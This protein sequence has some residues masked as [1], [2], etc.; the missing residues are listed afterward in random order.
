MAAT[1]AARGV[2]SCSLLF[3]FIL[4]ESITGALRKHALEM[5]E[6]L[7]PICPAFSPLADL[8]DCKRICNV[9]L[10]VAELKFPVNK[11]GKTVQASSQLIE[12]I[13]ELLDNIAA[14]LG[15][16]DI[17]VRPAVSLIA[18]T[19]IGL[20]PFPTLFIIP[21]QGTLLERYYM[22]MYVVLFEALNADSP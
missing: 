11:F 3:L 12:E 13:T 1:R 5:H 20:A 16:T 6:I 7:K 17:L 8:P 19:C 21:R 22:I 4:I 14:G 18:D 10:S 2:V 9:L 15:P